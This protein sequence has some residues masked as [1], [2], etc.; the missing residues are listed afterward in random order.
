MAPIRGPRS[1]ACRWIF[2]ARLKE[3]PQGVLVWPSRRL[4]KR[5]RGI[6]Y[7]GQLQPDAANDT[8]LCFTIEHDSL[9]VSTFKSEGG[10]FDGK[11]LVQAKGVP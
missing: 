7:R 5:A 6:V 3:C 11:V 10:L 2:L 1:G 9:T 8:G 4:M